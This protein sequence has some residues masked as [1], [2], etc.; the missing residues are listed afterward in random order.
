MK[1]SEKTQKEFDKLEERFKKLQDEIQYLTVQYKYVLFDA[2]ASKR[3]RDY[4][5]NLLREREQ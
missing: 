3:E 2:E 1:P 5:K 4:Y